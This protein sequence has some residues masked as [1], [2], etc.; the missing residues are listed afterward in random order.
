M[1]SVLGLFAL[2]IVLP[3]TLALGAMVVWNVHEVRRSQEAELLA[4]ARSASKTVDL[5]ITRVATIADAV[6]TSDAIGSGDWRAARQRIDRMDLGSVAWVAVTDQQG[7]S[8]LNTAI[9]TSPDSGPRLPRPP[10]VEVA[11]R[12]DR[13]VVSDLFVGR[14]T[15]RQ[16][17]AV[18]RA[19]PRT[20]DAMV[21]TVVAEPSVLLP[22]NAELGVNESVIVTIVDRR[23][24]VVARSQEH[25]RW[26]GSQATPRMSAALDQAK[27]NVVSSR[28]LDGNPT[29]VAYTRSDL[30]GWTTMVVI[31]RDEFLEPVIRN[32]L[33]FALLACVLIALGLGLSR[34][35]GR[36]IIRELRL[37]ELDAT[38]LGHGKLVNRRAQGVE[39]ID[40]VQA[41]L[42]SASHELRRRATRQQTMINELNHRVKNTLATVQSLAVQTFRT[43]TPEAPSKFD[44][45]LV[46]L[47]GAHDL[48]TETSWEAVDIHSVVAR[49]VDGPDVGIV[50]SGSEVKLAPH[51][52]LALCMC[53]HE[54]LTNSLK[55]GALSA[56]GGKVLLSWT[57]GDAGVEMLWR[58]QGGP[59][60]SPPAHRGFGTRLI[61]RL[62]KTELGGEIIREYAQ[63]GLVARL[64][65]DPPQ[66]DRW[67][68]D[69]D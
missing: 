5:K 35:F 28:S 33:A 37:L 1:R 62:I 48:L 45:R 64:R 31:P 29:V 46:A 27:E 19:V 4:I 13:P 67:R 44:Q 2:S 50:W 61:D 41:A 15:A 9:G 10:D 55:Y 42:S 26:Q 11:L 17:V 24:K 12:T 22:T 36:T 49:C 68:N 69:F 8:L 60:V 53:L 47:A 14:S 39:N 52:A 30:T 38:A 56:A 34:I 65:I 43:A 51:A 7:R 58:E 21:V 20:D 23:K 57:S 32:G 6:A 25:A 66:V 18:S 63:A 59:P 54:L 40:R 16:V 3:A